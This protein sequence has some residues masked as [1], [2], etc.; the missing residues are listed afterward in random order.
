[1]HVETV[2]DPDKALDVL[3]AVKGFMRHLSEK[4]KE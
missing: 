2:Y 1:M 4:L 3:N